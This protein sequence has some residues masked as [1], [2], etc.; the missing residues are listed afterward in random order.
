MENYYTHTYKIKQKVDVLPRIGLN[1]HSFKA[2][3]KILY[4][5]LAD[6]AVLSM[7]TRL[8]LSNTHESGFYGRHALFDVQYKQLID[9]SEEVSKRTLVMGA[10]NISSF[11]DFLKNTRLDELPAGDLNIGCL[12]ADHE[13]LI[14]YLGEDAKKCL[15]EFEDEVTHDLLVY[16]QCLHNKMAWVLGSD[17]EKDLLSA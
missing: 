5:L 3:V 12:L 14:Q 4:A 11:K 15:T 7:K 6:E 16:I 13:A 9:I 2:V 1:N 8:T 17:I 10:L